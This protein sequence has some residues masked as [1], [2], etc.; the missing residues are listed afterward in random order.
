MGRKFFI[1]NSLTFFIF[2]ALCV[3]TF[4]FMRS[5]LKFTHYVPQDDR[6]ALLKQINEFITNGN[7]KVE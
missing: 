4:I 7:K 2:C 6:E 3:G 1:N 5:S